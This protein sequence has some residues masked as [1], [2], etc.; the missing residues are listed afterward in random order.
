[1]TGGVEH[2][3]DRLFE[4]QRIHD[5]ASPFGARYF[6]DATGDPLANDARRA[7]DALLAEATEPA[8]FR[9]AGDDDP[10]PARFP[11]TGTPV[12]PA[13]SSPGRRAPS[14]VRHA[15]AIGVLYEMGYMPG[16]PCVQR[17]LAVLRERLAP[18]NV[19]SPVGPPT[20]PTEWN[21]RTRHVVWVLAM[22]AELPSRTI[23]P[24]A[25]AAARQG[26]ADHDDLFRRA[27]RYL[28]ADRDAPWIGLGEG[29]RQWSEY[30]RPG[31]DGYLRSPNLLNT[32]YA[33]I[34]VTR[35]ERHESEIPRRRFS[36][37]HPA[38]DE[39]IHR[40]A[41]GITVALSDRG[42]RGPRA[43]LP[44]GQ[45]D[46]PWARGPELP[47]GI[48]G[49][50]CLFCVEY[51]HLLG[52]TEG[53]ERGREHMALARRL[54]QELI[55]R[56][57]EW[58]S[59]VDVFFWE[60]RE[61]PARGWVC[62]SSSVCLRAVLESHAAPA[63]HP[64]VTAALAAMRDLERT[65]DHPRL[66]P[67]RT[68]VDPLQG[69]DDLA[70]QITRQAGATGSDPI[71]R[72]TA[73]LDLRLLD[74]VP[75]GAAGASPLSIHSAVMAFA[76][77]RRSVARTDPRELSAGARAGA[78]QRPESPF[79]RIQ[80][81]GRLEA[82]RNDESRATM[83]L[84]DRHREAPEVGPVSPWAVLALWALADR[85]A[86]TAAEVIDR[87]GEWVDAYRAAHDG[88]EPRLGRSPRSASSLWDNTLENLNRTAGVRLVT[89]EG[90]RLRLTAA[91]DTSLFDWNAPARRGTRGDDGADG[92]AGPGA[93]PGL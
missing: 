64:A 70:R 17:H 28:D 4:E 29:Q 77:Y 36:L 52:A 41:H 87:I 61:I 63:T 6:D 71:G 72:W 84:H 76:A 59:S 86:T 45:W 13:L 14:P 47:A 79:T 5:S 20:G 92:G 2:P 37:R 66:G 50:L 55:L 73:R 69:R 10:A 74:D 48:V 32:I 85:G 26:L 30:W 40:L 9:F 11:G 57:A 34:A 39:V 35:A 31:P 49:L 33:A 21:L 25:P 43:R 93:A 18:A 42:T 3:A 60:P 65:V 24:G 62:W 12:G 54:G 1:M 16:A 19:T 90:G 75:D 89:N 88:H 91:L 78:G 22:L 68:W 67:V 44:K 27:Y 23:P 83:H 7:L 38:P 8:G 80:I 82:S 53:E 56:A 51:A 58:E 81:T 15:M 46:E